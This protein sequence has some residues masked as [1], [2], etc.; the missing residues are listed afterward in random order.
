MWLPLVFLIFKKITFWFF[1]FVLLDLNRDLNHWF[2]SND[3]NQ[4][5]LHETVHMTGLCPWDSTYNSVMSMRQYIQ[6]GYVPETVHTTGLCPWDS[7][8]DGYVHETVH[9][10]FEFEF[11][12]ICHTTGWIHIWFTVRTIKHKNACFS[13]GINVGIMKLTHW[14]WQQREVTVTCH[15]I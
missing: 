13:S 9:I 10:E 6:Q 7:T 8:Y 3:L 15:T 5:T 12:F 2:K 4:T 11:E 14:K 1:L